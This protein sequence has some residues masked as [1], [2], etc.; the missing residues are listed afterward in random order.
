VGSTTSTAPTAAA[1]A[2]LGAVVEAE[3]IAGGTK[4]AA[5][6]VRLSVCPSVCRPFFCHL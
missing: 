5:V 6:A 1:E 4:G 3:A 2:L